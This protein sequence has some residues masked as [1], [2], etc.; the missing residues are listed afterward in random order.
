MTHPIHV[1]HYELRDALSE[2]QL[3]V[4]G[5]GFY[6][7][8]LQVLGSQLLLLSL[9]HLGD[10]VV[11]SIGPRFLL[12]YVYRVLDVLH[13]PLRLSRDDLFIHFDLAD[14]SLG[15][16]IDLGLESL[17]LRLLLFHPLVLLSYQQLRL[18]CLDLLIVFKKALWDARLGHAY[19]YNLDTWGPLVASF[20]QGI[21]KLLI[22]GVEL[23]Y[24]NLLQGVLRTELVDF[25]ATL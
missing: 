12:I 14:F 16:S 22:Q 8:L 10:L 2:V 9:D 11:V 23:V 13:L 19:R 6:G 18:R 21:C 5:D 4:V 20:L 7:E 24:K 25:M 1:L 15:F 17:G 3:S